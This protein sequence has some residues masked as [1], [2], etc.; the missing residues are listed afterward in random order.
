MG[1]GEEEE[2]GK[3]ASGK[4]ATA[5]DLAD[6]QLKKFFT[7]FG[8]TFPENSS[9]A[10]EGTSIVMT[11]TD[12]NLQRMAD[13]LQELNVAKPMV[14][15]EVKSIELTDEDLEELGFNWALNT[16][17]RVKGKTN[18]VGGNQGWQLGPGNNTDYTD[19]GEA[20]VMSML[21]SMLSSGNTTPHLIKGLNIFP[22]LFGSTKPFGSDVA[23][24][25][26][27]TINA[28][29]RSDRT[30]IVSAPKVLV[31]SG[32]QATVI[33]GRRY[34]YPE[35]WDELEIEVDEGNNEGTWSITITEPVPT[36]GESELYGTIFTVKP[37]VLDD[38]RT[39]R[40]EINPKTVSGGQR[41]NETYNINLDVFRDGQL[42][43]ELSRVYKI[44]RPVI[45][46]QEL[47][48]QVDVFHGETLVLGGLSDS[49]SSSRLD[50]IPILADIPFIG[51]LF[52]SH[53]EQSVRRNTLV[54]VTAKL[55]DNAG[56]P[57]RRLESNFGIPEIGR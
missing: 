25:L 12:E 35:S 52:Q 23:L 20:K 11:N 19:D 27:L 34:Y 53:S 33:M 14:Q 3:K 2:S 10:Q 9:I 13:V 30:E 55:M 15:V 44:W 46:T 29:D 7:L 41:D 57:V 21:N 54:F 50:K 31:N 48:V 28:L 1:G 43:K 24:N 39:I 5:V 51:R 17:S 6:E 45:K 26:T 42:V 47:N 18:R 22:D 37:T 36:F 16:L 32:E 49:R 56:V 38:N 4:A 40:M 8:V